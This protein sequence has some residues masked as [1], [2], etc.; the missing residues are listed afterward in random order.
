MDVR[1]TRVSWPVTGTASAT[2][3]RIIRASHPP[4]SLVNAGSG[5]EAGST[6]IIEENSRIISTASQNDGV[7]MHA[8]ENTRITWSGHLSRYSAEI[9][10]SITAKNTAMI[11][12]INV[13]WSVTGRAAP[14]RSVT[15]A[16]FAP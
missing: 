15:D 16:L 9:T 12:P 8:I 11:R 13:S 1:I 2:A 10:P 7:A 5:P 14:M 6:C 4:G 3:G